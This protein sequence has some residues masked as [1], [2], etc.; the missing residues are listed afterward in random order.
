MGPLAIRWSL[1][2][3][4]VV[5]S[6]SA[7]AQTALYRMN[8]GGGAVSLPQGTF[9]ADA[10][11]AGTGAGYVGGA[12]VDVVSDQGGIYVGG[13]QDPWQ[14]LH[15][16]GREGFSAYRF[17]V[18]APEVIV[19]LHLAEIVLHGPHLRSFG[20][21]IEGIPVL[22]DLDLAALHGVQYGSVFAARTVVSGPTV[23][24]EVLP[25]GDPALLDAIE[26]W[27]VP[28]TFATPPPASGLA[29]LGSYRR[30]ALTWD[31]STDPTLAGYVVERA[32]TAA[33]PWTTLGTTWASPPRW[34]DE[35]LPPGET[36][37]YRVTAVN[38]GGQ[39]SAPSAPVPA[40]VL[41]PAASALRLFE[42]TIAPE[43]LLFLDEHVIDLPDEEV[44]A[45]LTFAG[46]TQPIEVRYRGQS[47]RFMS[48]K[49]WKLKFPS[50][51]PFEG[52]RD[53]NF[54]A[55]FMDSSLVHEPLTLDLLAGL[56]HPAVEHEPVQLIVN[57][58]WRGVFDSVEQIDEQYL[59]A[60]DRDPG[61]SIYECDGNF[62]LLRDLEDYV[63]HYEKKTN[64]STGYDDLIAFLELLDEVP[65]ADLARELAAVF[66]VD[67]Y[68]GYL[69]AITL[70]A[71]GDS[72][73]HNAY[74]LHDFALQ[75]WELISWDHDGTWGVDPLLTL[76]PID[77][78]TAP[79]VPFNQLKS[80]VLEVPELRWR[81]C[82]K[83]A[84][85]LE[86]ARELPAAIDAA[87]AAVAADG[88]LDIFKR[89]WES[90][91]L[92]EQSPQAM[93]HFLD[94]RVPLLQAQLG[95]YQPDSPPTPVWL[96][97]LQVDASGGWVELYNAS[98]GVVDLSGWMLTDEIANPARWTLPAGTSLLPGGHL[99][100]WTDGDT[101]AG[102][103]H[104]PFTLD[105]AGGELGIFAADGQ[106]LMDF[107]DY[108]PQ[109]PGVSEG[110]LPDGGAFWRPMATPTP[111]AANTGAGNL[112]PLI[113]W[114]AHDPAIVNP[115]DAVTVS[116][117]VTDTDGVAAVTLLVQVDGGAVMPHA[118]APEGQ[119]RWTV[120]LP[121]QPAG[122][123]VSGLVQAEDGLGLAAVHAP[124][125]W[126]VELPAS[127]L[128]RV[129]ELM[130]SNASTIVDE[131]G[132]HE[133]WVELYNAGPST[134]DLSGL[135]L[136]D[137]FSQPAKWAIP[138][139]TLLAPG[140]HLLVWADDETAEGPLHAAFKLSASGEQV[141]LF[142]SGGTL[143]S[144][145]SFG[146]QASDVGFGPL[147]D[148][149]ATPVE[150]LD[151][152][153][154]ASNAPLP[155]AHA[156]F[157]L[158]NLA[159]SGI[160]L[161]A[162]GTAA[163]GEAISYTISGAPPGQPAAILFSAAVIAV[164]VGGAGV[165]LGNPLIMVLLATDASGTSTLPLVVPD[166]PALAGVLVVAQGFV[167]TGGLSNGVASVLAD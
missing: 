91:E 96:N 104:A 90:G 11:F 75:R 152:T 89:G 135:F 53:L 27:T 57:G 77:F 159:G 59:L 84:V 19:R 50:S 9:S 55:H 121:P 41:D 111:G 70:L 18:F 98:A 164:P 151:P 24:I 114:V 81:F 5:A 20:L 95:P 40:A 62:T 46:E 93:Q 48:K 64:E 16:D 110:R 155:G 52:R 79:Q 131:A 161:S 94:V 32:P 6:S 126:A 148:G 1:V 153:P 128:L 118:M 58:R 87:H 112:P 113:T 22:V 34:L 109:L 124:L 23:D 125:S 136:T 63:L 130:A 71:D 30:V 12:A 26:I 106:T 101:G 35:D 80:R 141:G 44:P 97:E 163:G 25:G 43:D 83:L 33:G 145:L 115:S 3:A 65:T 160:A 146:P 14:P 117:Q 105:A 73:R 39:S 31:H 49:S 140:G 7:A 103:L 107:D 157:D 127:S 72:V 37:W 134:A 85:L 143:L 56:G 61:G 8:C 54:K 149:G 92:L 132:D 100:V 78:G 99:V 147:P 36:H 116:C 74:L 156:S 119:H 69:A 68:L 66:D 108:L 28:P 10:P 17:R 165:L 21:A 144:G 51:A 88:P 129:N 137:N 122:A 67:D 138:A 167:K 45:L 142:D 123:T 38:L 4:L 158:G 150:L 162:S 60:R 29:A 82:E 120:T 133:D 15:A 154:G 166:L 102:P 42:L 139:G 13:W 86:E 2:L 76:L 47:S